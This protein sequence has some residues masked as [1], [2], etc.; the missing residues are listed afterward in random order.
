ML[1]HYSPGIND[2]VMHIVAKLVAESFQYSLKR[3]S[4]IVALQIFDVFQQE[5]TRT[6]FAEDPHNFKK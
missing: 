2:S 1:G 5:G 4:A 6:L 3:A